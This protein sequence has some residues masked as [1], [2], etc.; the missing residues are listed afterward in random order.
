MSKPFLIEIDGPEYAGKSTLLKMLTE[1]NMLNLDFN[2]FKVP[3]TSPLSS[4]LR[5]I[6]KQIEMSPECSAGIMF[7]SMHDFYTFCKNQNCNCLTDRGLISSVIYQGILNDCIKKC[8][9]LFGT[10]YDE[11]Y[12]LIINNFNYYRIVLSINAD[13]V[14]ERKHIRDNTTEFDVKDRYDNMEYNEHAK[15]CN[16]YKTIGS[17]GLLYHKD[18]KFNVERTF[19]IN[20]N[21]L[22]PDLVAE[23]AATIINDLTIF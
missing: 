1:S 17:G 15:L 12:K 14:I 6:V 23:R 5:P 18:F 8:P 19:I 13:T 21:N 2:V 3:G 7:A 10:L 16:Y 4:L 22:T 11:L 20:C 9:D